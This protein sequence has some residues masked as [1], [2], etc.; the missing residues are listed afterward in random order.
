MSIESKNATGLFFTQSDQLNGNLYQ[1]TNIC[2][3]FFKFYF[4]INVCKK[5]K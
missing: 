5:A 1:N 4:I 2:D 3:M